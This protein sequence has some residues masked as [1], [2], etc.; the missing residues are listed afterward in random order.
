MLVFFLLVRKKIFLSKRDIYFSILII[1]L[2]GY[3]GFVRRIMVFGFKN[4]KEYSF[5]FYKLLYKD[6]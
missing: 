1:F 3:K 4:S 5:K 6:M 2:R